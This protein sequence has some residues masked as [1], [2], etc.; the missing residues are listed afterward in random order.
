MIRVLVADDFALIR[1]GLVQWLACHD[2]L[3][4]VGVADDGETAV[5]LAI[6]L[7]PDVVLMDL[8]MPGLDG[9]AATAAITAACSGRHVSPAVIIL[10]TFVDQHTVRRAFDAGA[11][12]YLLKDTRPDA[13]VD[14][15]RSVHAGGMA[16]APKVA[17]LLVRAG[18]DEPGATL[19]PRERQILAL[20]A[21]GHGNKQIGRLLDISETTVKTHCTSLF[22]RIGVVDRTQAAIWALKYLPELRPAPDWAQTAR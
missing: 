5:R 7:R 9:I 20:I 2:D 22:T 10:T 19:T 8:A 17:P 16:I 4:V 6:E 15:I 13:L 12:G 14:G 11:H 1:D 18:G 3:D 21:E